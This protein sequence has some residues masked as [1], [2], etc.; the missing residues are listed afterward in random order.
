MAEIEGYDAK[1]AIDKVSRAQEA[2]V[3]AIGASQHLAQT[4][5][6]AHCPRQLASKFLND[7]E[8]VNELDVTQRLAS[9]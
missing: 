9:P 6:S 4:T 5:S 7:R 3:L 8:G 1:G 2:L